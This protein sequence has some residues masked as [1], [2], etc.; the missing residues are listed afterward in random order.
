[1]I[2]K[3]TNESATGSTTSNRVRT[4][5]TIQVESIFFD[6]QACVLQLKGI[7]HTVKMKRLKCIKWDRGN[8]PLRFPVIFLLNNILIP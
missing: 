2:R 5:L 1:M 6:T 4:I 3:V 7:Y 8:F